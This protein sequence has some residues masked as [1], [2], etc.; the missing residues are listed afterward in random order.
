MNS[1]SD[2][3]QKTN[4]KENDFKDIIYPLSLV[5]Q[6]GITVSLIAGTFILGGRY[7]DGLLKTSPLF[8]LL[9]GVLAFIAS[10][11]VVY[12]LVLPVVKKSEDADKR[13]R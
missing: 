11:Y 7:L 4:K 9:G 12:V 8:I 1:E 3:S 5:T 6:I 2:N 10:M 13:A